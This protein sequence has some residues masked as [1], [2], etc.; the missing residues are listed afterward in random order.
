MLWTG[1]LVDKSCFSKIRTDKN[2]THYYNYFTSIAS[3]SIRIID[4]LKGYIA[5]KPSFERVYLHLLDHYI[6]YNKI[7][8]AKEYFESLKNSP[9]F[10]RNSL[11]IL[12]EIQ[13]YQ[14]SS[15]AAHNTYLKAINAGKPSEALIK[16]FISFEITKRN[17]HSIL[18]FLDLLGLDST[19]NHLAR[20]NYYFDKSDYGNTIEVLKKIPEQFSE[21]ESVLYLKG[22]CLFVYGSYKEAENTW[23]EG[24]DVALKNDDRHAAIKFYLN[25]GYLASNTGKTEDAIQHY[26]R[27]LAT[28]KKINSFKDLQKSSGYL[29]RIYFSQNKIEKALNYF[30]QAIKIAKRIGN[31]YSR[32]S[33]YYMMSAQILV[34]MGRFGQAINHYEKSDTY[35]KETNNEELLFSLHLEI[36]AF[37]A[38][39][40]NDSLARFEYGQAIEWI[41]SLKDPGRYERMHYRYADLL[42]DGKNYSEV[43]N[44]YK[45]IV[46]SKNKFLTHQDKIYCQWKLAESYLKEQENNFAQVE[47]EKAIEMA[48]KYNKNN[49]SSVIENYESH[50]YLKLSDIAIKRQ[51]YD[52]AIKICDRDIIKKVVKRNETQ[53]RERYLNLGRAEMGKGNLDEAIR[54]FKNS[55]DVLEK[56]REII[57]VDNFRIGY[58]GKGINAYHSLIQCYL[59][60]FE[61]TGNFS[62]LEN[63]FRYLEKSR[64]RGLRDLIV[65][66]KTAIQRI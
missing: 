41:N 44:I 56:S 16:S 62:D 11:W 59:E 32:L 17:N 12:A 21:H 1:F 14:D 34:K 45:K 54:L 58:F 37:H 50:A 2:F 9:D 60:R 63:I 19:L 4:Q 23:M 35:A 66:E 64:G 30:I 46:D 39:M 43:R 49:N 25:L 24:L 8:E 42:F 10:L 29:G 13:S 15:G 47:F 33:N 51:N 57:E 6:Y 61:S 52:E 18:G 36:G 27:A 20:A 55:I 22:Y 53:A 5:D 7:N 28:A 26:E 3:D 31:E 38:K 48:N 65:K 40:K